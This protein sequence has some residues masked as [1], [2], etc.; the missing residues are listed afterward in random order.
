MHLIITNIAHLIEKN[1]VIQKHNRKHM[2]ILYK[3]LGFRDLLF[4]INNASIVVWWDLTTFQIFIVTTNGKVS[5]VKNLWA[6]ILTI[7]S[8][9]VVNLFLGLTLH[10][11]QI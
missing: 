7:K 3:R 10:K 11:P 9:R 6:N 8:K 2:N 1:Q 5:K 4:Q